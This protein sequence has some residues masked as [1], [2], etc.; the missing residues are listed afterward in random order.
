[1]N[2]TQLSAQARVRARPTKIIA[3]QLELMRSDE[4]LSYDAIVAD[5]MNK[6]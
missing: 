6:M 1:M 4:I 5:S 2:D 3:S